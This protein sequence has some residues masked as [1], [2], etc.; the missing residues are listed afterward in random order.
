MNCVWRECGSL[1]ELHCY[2]SYT[3]MLPSDEMP[4]R[5][6]RMWQFT[7]ICLGSSLCQP[8]LPHS[9]PNCI[10]SWL[11]HGLTILKIKRYLN[12]ILVNAASWLCARA[13]TELSIK[14]EANA[15]KYCFCG[16]G[17]KVEREDITLNPVSSVYWVSN[18]LKGTKGVAIETV[19]WMGRGISILNSSRAMGLLQAWTEPILLIV[20]VCACSI[21]LASGL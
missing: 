16:P 8:I 11:M 21:A 12:L 20:C 1:S 5:E 10:M 13:C 3:D 15:F 18:L 7:F 14:P 6:H 2:S 17:I 4:Y 19:N 9:N